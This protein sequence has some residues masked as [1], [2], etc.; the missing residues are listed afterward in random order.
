MVDTES[1]QMRKQVQS[2]Q[3]S[4]VDRHYSYHIITIYA[5]FLIILMSN[6]SLTGSTR[7]CIPHAVV[8]VVLMIIM[9]I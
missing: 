9:R 2:S 6:F 7:K 4:K 5:V 3:N 8:M 1:L